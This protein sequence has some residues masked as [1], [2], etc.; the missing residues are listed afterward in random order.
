MKAY[1]A[2][3]LGFADST[4]EFLKKIHELLEKHGFEVLDPWDQDYGELFGEAEKIDNLKDRRTYLHEKVNRV[5][6]KKNAELILWAD[7]LVAVLDGPDVDSGTASEIGFAYGLGK[8]IIGLRTDFRLA[9]DN[10]GSTVNL[11][12][13]YFIEVSSKERISRSLAELDESL[14]VIAARIKVER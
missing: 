11:Q 8:T 13:E 14:G 2:S 12:V 3:P 9:A 5:I 10:L 1:I 7:V 4:R 6:G